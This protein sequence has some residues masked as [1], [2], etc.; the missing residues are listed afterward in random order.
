MLTRRRPSELGRTSRLAEEQNGEEQTGGDHQGRSTPHQ[1][2]MKAAADSRTPGM[3]ISVHA[4]EADQDGEQHPDKEATMPP[5]IT[6][7]ARRRLQ[8]WKLGAAD[9]RITA[10][11][12]KDG[13][14]GR[15]GAKP[16][17][18]GVPDEGGGA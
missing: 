17:S 13:R 18:R 10:G 1:R 6:C 12:R 9:T 7:A 3:S 11:W 16:A 5:I 4:P 14:R 2:A 8:A 15:E